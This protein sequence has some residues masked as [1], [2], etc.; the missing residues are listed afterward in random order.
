MIVIRSVVSN[1]DMKI[2]SSRALG[3]KPLLILETMNV[4]L[5]F[6]Y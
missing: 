3:E 1:F 5:L 6:G 4:Q 2:L